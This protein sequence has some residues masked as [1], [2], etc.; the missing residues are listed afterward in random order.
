M[1]RAEEIRGIGDLRFM[2]ARV[3]LGQVG[4]SMQNAGSA[5]IYFYLII[6]N[7]ILQEL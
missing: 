1:E 2:L 7:R 6:L 4:T 5:L 3:T